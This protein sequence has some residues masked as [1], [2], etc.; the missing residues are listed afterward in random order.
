MAR[1][2]R[3]AWRDL[4]LVAALGAVAATGL[5]P[6]QAWYLSL[7]AFAVIL[8]R[9]ARA[10]GAGA[11]AWTGWAAGAG[12]FA[13]AL[14]WIVE[15]FLI[16]PEV[17][18]WM[19]P[20]ALVLMAGGL[21]LFWAAG[22]GLGHR[23]AREPA[24][25]VVAVALALTVTEMLRGIVLTG[26]PWA[27]P[28][29]V[30]AATPVAQGAALLGGGGLTALALLLAAAPAALG[31]RGG[32]A[33]VAAL[34][35]AWWGGQARLDRPMP[36]DRDVTV[37]LVQPAADQRIKWN[38]DEAERLFGLQLSM[39]AEAPRPDVAIW[40]E[41]A[42][43]YLF[44]EGGRVPLDMA[45]AARGAVV[46]AGVQRLEG[47]RAF[48]SL[49]AL[50]PAGAVAARY[51]KHHLVPFG[52]YVPFGDLAWRWFGLRG[53]AAQLG[54]GFSA[55]PG[56][57]ILDLGPRLGRVLPMICYEAIFSWAARVPG[58]RPDWL[59][60]ITNDAWFGTWQGPFQHFDQARLRAIE[61]G[62]PLVRV[63]NTGVTAMIDARGQVVADLPFG[64][65]GFLDAA[66]PG[67]LAATPYARWGDAPLWALLLAGLGAVV[68]AGR[69]KRAA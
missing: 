31:W 60:Q 27:M 38:P 36:P 49:V 45:A 4:L 1:F 19:A 18:G 35:L 3:P 14:S 2:A 9:I 53:F 46:I 63:A 67:A 34:G 24:A 51:D 43:P 62:L 47:D 57:A 68:A 22:A 61:Q 13:L 41:T 20:F 10:P 54:S 65:P 26:F 56:P 64:E 25:R 55:G 39:T 33:A 37:R 12:W 16:E 42:V 40:P 8:W 6:T 48:N 66:L 21:A 32:V 50:D 69:G 28:G 52:E 58:Q 44:E 59:L 23:L 29:H 30:W 5:A 17:Y 15:P 11:A 7:P